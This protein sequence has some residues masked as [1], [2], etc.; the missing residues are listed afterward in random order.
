MATKMYHPDL[1]GVE[2]EVIDPRGVAVHRQSGWR[3]ED[4]MPK[5]AVKKAA[6]AAAEN[7]E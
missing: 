6:D 2:Y 4:E 3:T 1:P 7:K 5:G